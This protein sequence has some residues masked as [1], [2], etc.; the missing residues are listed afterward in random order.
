MAFVAKVVDCVVLGAGISGLVSASI[1]ATQA[2][3]KGNILVIDEFAH[4]G[5]NHISVDLGEYTF[6]IGSFFFADRSPLM[7]HFPDLLSLNENQT[8]GTYSIARITPSGATGRYPF[9]FQLDFRNRGPWAVL[10]ILMSLV[11]SRLLKDQSRSAAH[12]A[13][14]WMG[15]R[16]FVESGLRDYM[17]RFYG[18]DPELIEGEFAKKRMN[19]I[20]TNTN[21]RSLWRRFR[22]KDQPAQGTS[23]KQLVRPRAGFGVLYGKARET[24]EAKGVNFRL[25]AALK[26]IQGNRDE[27]FTLV[28]ESGERLSTKRLIATIP[29]T[30]TLNLC[31]RPAPAKIKAT[32]LMTLF[33]SFSGSRGFKQNVLYNFSQNGRWKRL[34]M[35]SDFYG[36]V[37]GRSY[38]SLE[39]VLQSAADSADAFFEDFVKT[40]HQSQL[41]IGDLKLEGHRLTESAYPVYTMGAT[42]AATAAIKELADLGIESFGRQGGFDYQP[43]AAVSTKTAEKALGL[44]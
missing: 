35:H 6:D 1:L 13:E 11:K 2:G 33:I 28:F 17:A 39:C 18:V 15:G 16:F 30:R 36:E 12:Y 37:E 5:G 24:L 41:F 31:G 27:G 20:E 32:A 10:R 38:F 40:V 42:K 22:N 14:Y 7:R 25:G 4:L 44:S 8:R 9:D 43:I 21:V 3:G 19:W 34:T 23:P 29:L 26:S